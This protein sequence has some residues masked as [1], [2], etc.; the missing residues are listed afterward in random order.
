MGRAAAGERRGRAGADGRTGDGDGEQERGR[1]ERDAHH[2]VRP[3]PSAGSSRNAGA[4]RAERGPDRVHGVE[5]AHPRAQLVVALHGVAREQRQR[6]AHERGRDEEHRERRGQ[7]EE[8]PSR[9][10]PPPVGRQRRPAAP[11]AAGSRGR[12]PPGRQRRRPRCRAP[13]ARRRARAA[14]PV[15]P[16]LGGGALRRSARPCTPPA[17]PRPPART[18]RTSARTAASRRSGR[19]GP[20]SPRGGSSR[21]AGGSAATCLKRGR[22]RVRLRRSS[23][24]PGA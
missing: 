14:A 22:G 1:V 6:R 23:R 4:E 11:A 21:A 20:P 16:A 24:A 3:S 15:Q 19:R 18:R 10:R 13:A 12:A 17:P 8:R 7:V 5:R 2:T 9:G